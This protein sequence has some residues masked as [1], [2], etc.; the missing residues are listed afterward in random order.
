MFPFPTISDLNAG[1]VEAQLVHNADDLMSENAG[2]LDYA[3]QIDLPLATEI[4]VSF[5]QMD[6]RVAH[7]ARADPEQHLSSRPGR[8]EIRQS[9]SEARQFS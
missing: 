7:A 4:Q 1:G 5:G 8:A 2:R 6:V 9:L 3:G